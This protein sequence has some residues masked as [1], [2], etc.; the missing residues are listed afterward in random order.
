MLIAIFPLL[1]AV[2]GL[3]MWALATSNAKVAEAGKILFFCGALITTWI[4]AQHTIRIG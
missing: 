1:I 3:L 2:L 4:L